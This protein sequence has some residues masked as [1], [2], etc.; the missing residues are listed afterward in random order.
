MRSIID[1]ILDKALSYVEKYSSY[2]DYLD[3]RVQE[4]MSRNI[5]VERGSVKSISSSGGVIIGVR[6]LISGSW[7]L[8]STNNVN[9]MEDVFKDAISSAK[10]LSGRKK[11][12]VGLSDE[13]VYRDRRRVDFKLGFDEA[14][15]EEKKKILVD[16][17]NAIRGYDSRIVDSRVMYIE[18]SGVKAFISSE[19]A[20]IVQEYP[21][22]FIYAVAVAR[23]GANV[24]RYF[25]V[26]GG[27]YGL[28]LLMDLD[29]NEFSLYVAK[30]AVEMLG[31]VSPP[32]GELTV[33]M[34]G[35]V[36]GVF[37]HEVFG[38][39]CEAD[40]VLHGKSF[41]GKLLGEKIGSDVVSIVDDATVER[42][43]GSYFYDDEGVPAQRK[44]LLDRGVLK[45]FMH[46]RETAYRMGVNS[47]GNGRAMSPSH[48][49]YV[50]MSNTFILPG[51]WSVEEIIEDTRDGVY[52]IGE[53]G[54]MEDPVGGGFQVAALK[55]YLIENGEATK[56]LKGV[57]I[58]GKALDILKRIDAVGKDF[59]LDPGMCGKGYSSDMVPVTTGGPTVRVRGMMVGGA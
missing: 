25:K 32:T 16:I 59:I 34:D 26:E 28:E 27:L 9:L 5:Q 20:S 41:L 4:G 24:Q 14:S 21:L 49:T 52:V 33:V 43:Y 6:A 8:S 50:R 57:T 54:G 45:M 35:R 38:H 12:D 7:G 18:A 17:D 23:E 11:G 2:A 1:E 36:S 10:A 53:M 56:L 46:S 29:Y 30:N 40:N 51:D 19:G 39:A 42:A 22:S 47:T 15:V 44:V 37:A 31:A 48:R 13:K 3:V 58:S 55:A